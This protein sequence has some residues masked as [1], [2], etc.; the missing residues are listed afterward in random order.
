MAD[1]PPLGVGVVG[2]GR[3]GRTLISAA[4]RGG[5]RV[6]GVFDEGGNGA[7]AAAAAGAVMV[8]SLERLLDTPGV[9]AVLVATSHDS[10]RSVSEAALGAG[11]HVFCEKPMALTVSDCRAMTSAARAKGLVLLVGQVLRF[12]PGVKEVD[13]LVRSN[14]YGRPVMASVVRCDDL[15][16]AGWW[17]KRARSGGTVFSPGVHEVD[18]LNLWLGEPSHALALAAPRI[19][20]ALD[21]PDSLVVTL[22]YTSGAIA[23]AVLSLSDGFPDP[24]GTHT[25]RLLC[26][27]GVVLLDVY[28]SPSLTV[29]PHGGVPEVRVAPVWDPQDGVVAELRNFA[30]VIRGEERPFVSSDDATLAVA[31]C[32]AVD[33]SLA[34]GGSVDIGAILGAAA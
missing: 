31:V 15:P 19:Q 9:D 6:N 30:A 17:T 34:G 3:F 16:R 7:D 12:A 20:A 4:L 22:R 24:R 10:H 21:Y 14:Q 2:C 32:Q 23:S 1:A 28:G 5:L 13:A 11:R 8:P 26:E 33:L 29:Q 25:I 18:L 27:G